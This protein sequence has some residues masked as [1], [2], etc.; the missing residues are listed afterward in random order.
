[1]VKKS[2]T[3]QNALLKQITQLLKLWKPIPREG[4]LAGVA[5]KAAQGISPSD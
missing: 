5:M 2:G 3:Q 1:M 4:G